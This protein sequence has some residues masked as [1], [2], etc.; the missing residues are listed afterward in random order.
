MSSEFDT[1]PLPRKEVYAL[2]SALFY[3]GLGIVVIPEHAIVIGYDPSTHQY[4][5]R[6]PMFMDIEY[7]D[8]LGS[9]DISEY[10]HFSG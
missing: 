6:D 2:H 8:Y 9:N 10:L 5:K 7:E 4:F 1:N 3:G